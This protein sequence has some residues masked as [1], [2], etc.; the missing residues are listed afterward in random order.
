[1]SDYSRLYPENPQQCCNWSVNEANW[2]QISP[3]KKYVNKRLGIISDPEFLII[4]WNISL[5]NNDK[6]D[7]AL[8]PVYPSSY[9][10]RL[11]TVEEIEEVCDMEIIRWFLHGR[12]T[13]DDKMVKYTTIE[14]SRNAFKTIFPALSSLIYSSEGKQLLQIVFMMI[15]YI[16]ETRDFAQTEKET[17]FSL[18]EFFFEF[19]ESLQ[20]NDVFKY[21]Q[22][23][24]GFHFMGSPNCIFRPECLLNIFILDQFNYDTGRNISNR[25]NLIYRWD[26]DPK[27]KRERK[28]P[29]QFHYFEKTTFGVQFGLE[30]MHNIFQRNYIHG[31]DVITDH[32]QMIWNRF[33]YYKKKLS[34]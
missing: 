5:E 21:I 28:F 25:L 23:K 29:L 31:I 6:D 9:D 7:R 18:C 3:G 16:S 33:N 20:P 32:D 12:E 11:F 27:I 24:Q 17:R 19:L 10:N 4:K 14:K 26:Y 2:K 8:L 22:G 13:I 34:S 30:C 1:M 15:E